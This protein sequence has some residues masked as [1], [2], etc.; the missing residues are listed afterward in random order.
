[1]YAEETAVKIDREITRILTEAHETARGILAKNRDQLE[2]VT[3][4][5][6]DVEVMEGDE[7][8]SILGLPRAEDSPDKAPLPALDR[9]AQ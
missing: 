8:R 6:L 4:R 7:L 9:P 1:M 5:L 3:R 2:K